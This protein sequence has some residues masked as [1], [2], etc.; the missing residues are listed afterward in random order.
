MA[1][2]MTTMNRP[3][4]DG[5][6]ALIV[7]VANE[8]S[9]ANGCACAFHEVGA[10]LAITYV[11]ERPRSYVEPMARRLEA[12][13]FMPLDVAVPSQLEAV[14]EGIEREWNRL[15]IVVHSIS[16]GAGEAIRGRLVDCPIDDFSQGNGRL[17]PLVRAAGE[18]RRAVDARRRHDVRHDV[19]R[20]AAGRPQLQRDGLGEG[21]AGSG[22]PLPGLRIEHAA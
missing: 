9:I 8:H 20:C 1:T 16:G 11:N 3:L 17:G 13:I 22:V 12:P 14:F 18:A 2:Q 6:K 15:D 4:L 10:E 5:R 19:S 7:G 21:R